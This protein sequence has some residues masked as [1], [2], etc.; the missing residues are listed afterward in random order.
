M[1]ENTSIEKKTSSEST[2]NALLAAGGTAGAMGVAGAAL[3]GALCPLCIVATPV[4]LGAGMVKKL[5]E[6]RASKRLAGSES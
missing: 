2:A 3:T 6:R 5:W 1:D 4:L